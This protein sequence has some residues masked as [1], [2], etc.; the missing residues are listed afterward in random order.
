L[1]FDPVADSHQRKDNAVYSIYS[2]GNIYP[3]YIIHL[4]GDIP[5]K[6]S[7]PPFSTKLF[8]FLTLNLF[9]SRSDENTK[10]KIESSFYSL[11]NNEHVK[12]GENNISFNEGLIEL[13]EKQHKIL[14]KLYGKTSEHVQNGLNGNEVSFKL[15]QKTLNNFLQLLRQHVVIEN[16]RLYGFLKKID[17]ESDVEKLQI[18]MRNIQRAV[19]KFAQSYNNVGINKNNAVDFLEKWKGRPGNSPEAKLTQQECIGA[20]LTERVSLEEEGLY[21]TYT[22][23]GLDKTGT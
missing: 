17:P 16:L 8:D 10:N 14:F 13:L 15:A 11:S 2:N 19:F 22:Q 1:V 7:T 23:I 4:Q 3:N 5:M 21:A 6:S 20:I 9:R 18:E 12:K